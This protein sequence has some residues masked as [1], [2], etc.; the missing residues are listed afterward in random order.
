[1]DQGKI[2]GVIIGLLGGWLL[3]GAWSA[4]SYQLQNG[5]ELGEIFDVAFSIRIM[6]SIAAFIAG[7]A[8]L[9]ELKGGA[10]LSGIAAFLMGVL[11]IAMI[12]MGADKALWQDEIIILFIMTA[13]F[14]GTMVARGQASGEFADDQV[15]DAEPPV[16]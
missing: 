4:I 9:I 13:L 11:T 5:S 1:M 12:A 15:D 10:W 8:A 16:G 3:W 2:C 6:S 7:I 14:L